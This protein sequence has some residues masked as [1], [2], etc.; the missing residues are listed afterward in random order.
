[1]K[2]IRNQYL[3]PSEAKNLVHLGFIL[4]LVQFGKVWD[5]Y[6]VYVLSGGN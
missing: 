6:E 4:S 1:M 5:K 2:Y 3:T